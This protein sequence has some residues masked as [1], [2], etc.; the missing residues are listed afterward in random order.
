[1]ANGRE[2][3]IF[4]PTEAA[5]T[6][7]GGYKAALG[8]EAQKRAAYLSS[9]D[10][11][12]AELEEMK[13]EFEK[14]YELKERGLEL[15][16]RRFEEMSAYEEAMIGIQK[17]QIEAQRY[18]TRMSYKAAIGGD[19]SLTGGQFQPFVHTSDRPK[20]P[21]EE[22]IPLSW[23]SEQ[24]RGGYVSEP[25]R[26]ASDEYMA[27]LREWEAT[28]SGMSQGFGSGEPENIGGTWYA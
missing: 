20:E 28:G 12:Y 13:S 23:L 26:S 18:G 25:T 19:T 6:K 11:F 15:E 7:P 8:A 14:T 16:E 1:M 3:G 10:Q 21:E 24:I 2:F 27:A 22:E 5:Y 4:T 9:M 17:E